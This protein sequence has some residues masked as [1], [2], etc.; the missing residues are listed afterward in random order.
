MKHNFSPFYVYF[1]PTPNEDII[2][3]L[4][5]KVSSIWCGGLLSRFRL[6]RVLLYNG[7]IRLHEI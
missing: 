1:A 4:G 2:I 6:L 5:V 3:L 7:K